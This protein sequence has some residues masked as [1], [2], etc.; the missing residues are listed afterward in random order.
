MVRIKCVVIGDIDV[1][2]TWLINTYIN[3]NPPDMPRPTIFDAYSAEINSDGLLSIWDTA[4]DNAHDKLRSKSYP[5]TDV[6]LICFAIDNILSFKN[7]PKWV[8]E[9]EHIGAPMILVGTKVDVRNDISPEEKIATSSGKNT[10]EKYGFKNYIE[11]SALENYNVRKVFD[12]A[13]R[14]T[15][16]EE[17]VVEKARCCGWFCCK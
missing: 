7:I 1:G 12:E 8:G 16:Q 2:K 14:A 3:G 17:E 5:N 9:I 13:I 15:H 11:C 4:G 10:A 6:F